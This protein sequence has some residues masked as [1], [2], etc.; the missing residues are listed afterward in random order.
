[1]KLR[2]LAGPLREF[3]GDLHSFDSPRIE[4]NIERSGGRERL[5]NQ[6]NNWPLGLSSP[7][8]QPAETEEEQ[9]Q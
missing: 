1:M 5:P 4:N 3:T 8:T 9:I 6:L 2:K 7:A